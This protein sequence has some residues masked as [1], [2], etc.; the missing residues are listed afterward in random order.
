M[1]NIFIIMDELFTN[2]KAHPQDKKTILLHRST[3]VRLLA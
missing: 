2:L 1:I 3:Q